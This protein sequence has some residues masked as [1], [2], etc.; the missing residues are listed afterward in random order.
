M[1]AAAAH[2]VQGCLV[3]AGR[4][5]DAAGKKA[6]CQRISRNIT[7][8]EN[9]FRFKHTLL[10]DSTASFALFR[11]PY[12]IE[13]SH[14]GSGP[15]RLLP[16]TSSSCRRKWRKVDSSSS[17]IHEAGMLPVKLFLCSPGG[18]TSQ[19]RRTVENGE[20]AAELP[21]SFRPPRPSKGPTFADSGLLGSSTWA[22]WPTREAANPSDCS[23]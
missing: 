6:P 18:S 10:K 2:K 22:G 21:V 12:S 17:P 13:T 3:Q 14:E 7:R 16:T 23:H 9:T 8:K 1:V 20:T 4:G 15:V 5:G 19:P 11:N